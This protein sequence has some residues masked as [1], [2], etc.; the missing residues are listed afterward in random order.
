LD[1][2]ARYEEEIASACSKEADAVLRIVWSPLALQRIEEI[3]EHIAKDNRSAA[4]RTITRIRKASLRLEL[5][6]Y[7]G[8][9]GRNFGYRELVVPGTSYLIPYH[10]VDGAIEVVSVMH[11]SQ[12]W[13]EGF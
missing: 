7:S 1:G 5:H 3:W 13:P 11:G 6:P 9:P 10:F 4:N 2:I 12:E 8:R